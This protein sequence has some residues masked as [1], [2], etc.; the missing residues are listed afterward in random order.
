[1]LQ[2][3][4]GKFWVS[5]HAHVLSG[6]TASTEFLYCLLTFYPI[7]GHVTGVAQPKLTQANLNRIPV[8]AP[9]HV[10]RDAFQDLI[11]PMFAQRFVLLR[12]NQA[13]RAAR[14]LLLPRLMSGEI[15]V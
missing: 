5:N 8:V 9:T 2:L 13:L 1:M 7:G 15:A 10:L 12:Q 6:N 14:D 3:V 4:E 11:G